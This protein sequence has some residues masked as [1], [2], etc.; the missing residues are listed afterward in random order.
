MEQAKS[1]AKFFE[2]L[3]ADLID[4][5]KSEVSLLNA[6]S[7]PER[8]TT[9]EY[10]RQLSITRHT[11]YRWKNRGLIKTEVIG[12]KHYVLLDADQRQKYQRASAV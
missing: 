7:A 10:C 2:D 5:I 11:L 3:K 9:T 8:I 12:G 6:R 4:S 1:I